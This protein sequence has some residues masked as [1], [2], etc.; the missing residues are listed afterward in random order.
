MG[1]ETRMCL[2]LKHK[3]ERQ[4]SLPGRGAAAGRLQKA[5][6]HAKESS[7]GAVLGTELSQPRAGHHNTP[8]GPLN[9]RETPARPSC[10]QDSQDWDL[11]ASPGAS[12]AL[13]TSTDGHLIPFILASRTP[14]PPSAFASVGG[15]PG[16]PHG[17]RSHTAPPV[18][19][20]QGFSLRAFP[21]SL[22][23]LICLHA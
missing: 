1:K 23:I 12:P 16:P 5:G 10:L 15:T 9:L 22:C 7:S 4:L 20:P 8:P 6:S 14:T 17:A 3:A 18:H 2:T 21:Q 11:T 13:I 19:R